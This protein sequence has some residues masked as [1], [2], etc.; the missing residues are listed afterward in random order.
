MQSLLPML[1]ITLSGWHSQETTPKQMIEHVIRRDFPHALD[2]AKALEKQWREQVASDPDQKKGRTWAAICMV[3]Y[4]LCVQAQALAMMQKHEEADTMLK[5]AEVY[6]NRWELQNWVVNSG[7]K[8]VVEATR[9]FLLEKKGE[10]DAAQCAYEA[11]LS[12]YARERLGIL[13]F[14]R[15]QFDEARRWANSGIAEKSPTLGLVLAKLHEHEGKATEARDAC[16]QASEHLARHLKEDT[17]QFLPMYFYEG[18]SIEDLKVR[19]LGK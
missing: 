4:Y 1:L 13:S 12:T 15:G 3:G 7:W 9:G 17:G 19:L 14:E 2:D 18:K 16:L 8:D 10:L 5:S 6:G 11:R